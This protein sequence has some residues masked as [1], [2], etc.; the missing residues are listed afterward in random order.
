MHL[1]AAVCQGLALLL[2][3]SNVCLNNGL[4]KELD[5]FMEGVTFP[6][7]CSLDIGAKLSIAAA[8]SFFASAAASFC[9]HRAEKAEIE[10]ELEE[11]DSWRTPLI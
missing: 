4:V 1:A 3:N 11:E 8:A 5:F 7:T 9:A 2:L 10:K 6:E